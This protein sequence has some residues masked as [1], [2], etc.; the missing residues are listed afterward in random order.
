MGIGLYDSSDSYIYSS[1]SSSPE[2]SGSEYNP[3]TVHKPQK[4]KVNRK[5]KCDGTTKRKAKTSELH[6][7]NVVSVPF[8]H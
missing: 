5:S 8:A 3:R 7:H 1:S 2:S 6:G 4:K